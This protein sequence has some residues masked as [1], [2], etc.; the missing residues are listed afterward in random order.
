MLLHQGPP[1]WKL[2]FGLTPDVTP[3]LREMMEASITGNA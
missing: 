3:E 1:A 2:W